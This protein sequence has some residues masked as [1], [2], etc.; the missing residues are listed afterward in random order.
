MHTLKQEMA[1]SLSSDL[2]VASPGELKQQ[3]AFSIYATFGE[4][5]ETQNCKCVMPLDFQN[6]I[7]SK[8]ECIGFVCSDAIKALRPINAHKSFAVDG[9][10]TL[11]PNV[12]N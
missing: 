8:S 5:S 10:I 3:S 1:D 11:H 2:Y 4:P 9:R 6:A 7:A 12:I